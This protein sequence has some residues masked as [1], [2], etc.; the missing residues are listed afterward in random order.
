MQEEIFVNKH[1]KKSM[2]NNEVHIYLSFFLFFMLFI[3]MDRIKKFNFP[4]YDLQ[5]FSYTHV[6]LKARINTLNMK[7]YTTMLTHERV[8]HVYIFVFLNALFCT[9]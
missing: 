9:N 2:H 6:Y 5:E 7:M 4:L 8:E 3:L 1:L